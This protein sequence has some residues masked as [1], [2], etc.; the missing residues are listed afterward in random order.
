MFNFSNEK[1]GSWFTFVFSKSP[2][3]RYGIITMK[4]LHNTDVL[5]LQFKGNLDSHTM[6]F[7]DPFSFV[8]FSSF[9]LLKNV[10][11]HLFLS[12]FRVIK[13]MM[14]QSISYEAKMICECV[15]FSRH[16]FWM[17]HVTIYIDIFLLLLNSS[18]TITCIDT[19]EFDIIKWHSFVLVFALCI[20]TQLW[21]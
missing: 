7:I 9:S 14:W 11:L 16:V 15:S 12:F 17:K 8:S 10:L 13:F 5:K 21:V 2:C 6:T 19:I 20:I 18:S 4:I 3:K 1:E